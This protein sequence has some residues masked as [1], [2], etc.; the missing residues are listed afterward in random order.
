MITNKKWIVDSFQ[1]LTTRIAQYVGGTLSSTK[2]QDA[3]R[4]AATP[5]TRAVLDR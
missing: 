4:E 2:Q 3:I 5:L 1:M